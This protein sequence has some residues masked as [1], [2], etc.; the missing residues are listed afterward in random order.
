MADASP[1]ERAALANEMLASEV[2]D[3]NTAGFEALLSLLMNSPVVDRP[4]L[5]VFEKLAEKTQRWDD[6]LVTCEE[7]AR[8]VETQD[9]GHAVELWLRVATAYEVRRDD[10]AS[11]LIAAERA[12][13]LDPERLDLLVRRA[14]LHRRRE[15]WQEHDRL[16]AQLGHPSG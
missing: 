12:S 8:R 1:A 5:K 3:E 7:V 14:E 9:P 15:E 2:P 13:Q 10:T 6:Y 11:A 16:M 4:T